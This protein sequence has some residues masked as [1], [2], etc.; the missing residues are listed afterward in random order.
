MEATQSYTMTIT[1]MGENGCGHGIYNN[2]EE[3]ETCIKDI[4][5]EAGVDKMHNCPYMKSPWAL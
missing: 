4:E 5:I 3:S 2:D 1:K